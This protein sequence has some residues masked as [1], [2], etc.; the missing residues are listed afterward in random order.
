MTTQKFRKVGD[1]VF[2]FSS[3]CTISQR[4]IS[5]M[6]DRFDSGLCDQTTSNA[7]ALALSQIMGEKVKVFR[8]NGRA[9]FEGSKGGDTLPNTVHT[10]LE[11]VDRGCMVKPFRFSLNPDF[12]Q[13]PGGIR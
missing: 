2:A 1:S 5:E 7:V 6:Y 3:Y 11:S 4:H 9:V 8:K 10:W 12:F 13:A